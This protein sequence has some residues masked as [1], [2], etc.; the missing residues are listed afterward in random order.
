MPRAEFF[1]RLGFYVDP[2]FLDAAACARLRAVVQAAPATPAAV[3]PT[4]A[5]KYQT[6]FLKEE[7]RKTDVVAVPAEVQ[8]EVTARLMAVK[9]ELER[10]FGLSL[11]GCQPLD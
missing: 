11:V 4:L 8:A 10:H 2:R 3:V 9:P 1:T 7:V 6:T 5:D